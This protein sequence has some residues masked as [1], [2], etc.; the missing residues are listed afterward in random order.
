MGFREWL[1]EEICW[2]G[3]DVPRWACIKAFV[4]EGLMPLLRRYKYV[5]CV[6]E[7]V[8]KDY[9]G[10]GLYVNRK[11]SHLDSVWTGPP[12][13]EVPH[14]EDV[15][16]F[17]HIIGWEEW[18]AFWAV[19]GDWTDVDPVQSSRGADR[20]MDIAA[21]ALRLIDILNSPQTKILDEIIAGGEEEDDG[22]HHRSGRTA[23]DSYI[24]ESVEYNGWG[25]YRK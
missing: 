10:T 6:P 13:E 24:L 12:N 23:V 7:R 17:H 22:A 20:R 8:V 21:F 14:P 18:E 11:R 5:L 2:R 16:H 1:K 3:R 15:A 19:W 9:I 25:G 4:E